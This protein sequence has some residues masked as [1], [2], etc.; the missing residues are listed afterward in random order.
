[1]RNA[2]VKIRELAPEPGP[3]MLES[4]HI[5]G[6]LDELRVRFLLLF[7]PSSVSPPVFWRSRL[8]EFRR[9]GHDFSQYSG[10][11]TLHRAGRRS[12]HISGSAGV[13]EPRHSR[14]SGSELKGQPEPALQPAFKLASAPLERSGAAMIGCPT[15]GSK[16][17]RPS[18]A[19]SPDC[20]GRMGMND[21][22][23]RHILRAGADRGRTA[24]VL[25]GAPVVRTAAVH[26]GGILS[27]LL[28][29]SGAGDPGRSG[30][31]IAGGRQGSGGET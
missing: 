6:S 22:R 12:W 27:L 30:G 7:W 2:D 9:G 21:R 16:L 23:R 8:Y 17:L 10:R 25:P 31:G 11:T 4:P 1:M 28:P 18:H 13:A 3:Q 24:G 19:N 5:L 26:S 29:R 20:C 14:F 15:S